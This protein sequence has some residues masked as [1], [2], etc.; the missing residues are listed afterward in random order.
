MS[1]QT[2]ES[3]TINAAKTK[4]HGEINIPNLP[5]EEKP[6]GFRGPVWRFSGNPVI[7]RAPF[8]RAARVYNSAVIPFE[9]NF[10]GVFRV[11]GFDAMPELHVG[12]STDA[13]NWTFEEESIQFFDESGEPAQMGYTYDPRVT[14]VE[15]TYYV[16]WCNEFHGPTIGLAKTKDFKHFTFVG[17]AFLPYNRNGVLFPR[18]IND[19]FLMLSRP[20]DSGHTPFGDIFLSRSPDMVYWG[21][22]DFVM[23]STNE[24]D[25]WQNTKIGAGPTPIETEEGWLIFYHGVSTL[26]NGLVYSMGAALLDREDPSKVL[27]RSQNAILP[28]AADYETIGHVAN[29]IFPCAALVDAPTG[30]I[31]VYY[32]A[33]DTVT[34]IAFTQVDEILAYLKANSCV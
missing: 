12:R 27:L 9:G 14:K 2:L 33:A 4:I 28:P 19:E 3:S 23:G 7:K 18:K 30:R 6:E 24:T 31:A 17:N 10:I 13:I 8:G 21:N 32:G 11:D 22:H 5:W 15:D 1:I 29:V 20:S 16:Q 34:S 26:C 25:W